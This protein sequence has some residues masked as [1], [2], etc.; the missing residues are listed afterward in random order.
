M[1]SSD[2]HLL[3]HLLSKPRA[4]LYAFSEHQ[5]SAQ[6][7]ADFE[8]LLSRRKRGEPIAYITG[9]RGFWSF[10]L[11]VSPDTLIP[12]PETELLVELVL[13]LL[14]PSKP[15]S[16]LD[17]G[18]GSG[19]IALA[20][21]IERPLASV[22]AVDASLA[23]LKVAQAN[24]AELK[25]LNVQFEHSNWYASIKH[26]R[27]NVIVSNP[28]YIEDGD[29]HLNQGDLRFEPHSAL[30][31][32]ADGLADIRIIIAGAR[33]HLEPGGYLLLEHGWQQGALVRELFAQY[34][35]AEVATE[36][37]LEQRDR[38]SMGKIL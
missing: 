29:A 19:A 33:K 11:Q 12:R 13:A 38:V 6:Q 1:C 2:L 22:C 17:M 28:P 8:A 36:Q 37:D 18:T 9:R 15:A 30:A 21:A 23:A 35:F 32:G 4:W 26:R 7:Q 10:D 16:V 14:H 20:I 27:F 5:I 25:L 24:A 34:C 3:A 31:S